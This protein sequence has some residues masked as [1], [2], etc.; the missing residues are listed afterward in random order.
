MFFPA[1]P[2]TPLF[3]L[4]PQLPALQQKPNDAVADGG[5]QRLAAEIGDVAELRRQSA[6]L[7][8]PPSEGV[9]SP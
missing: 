2:G 3:A 9:W 8:E 6:T 1:V 4:Q 7:K 5:A